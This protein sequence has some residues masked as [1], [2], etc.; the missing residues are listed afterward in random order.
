[1]SLHICAGTPVLHC[2]HTLRMD[3]DEGSDQNFDDTSLL[4]YTK[5]VFVCFVALRPK[6]TAMVME[7]QS[8]HLTT[9][10]LGK[11]EQQLTSAS[12]TYLRL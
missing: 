7:G 12:C 5:Y 11:L 8:V 4:V 6:S 2:S 9:P 10:F 3:V 1:M